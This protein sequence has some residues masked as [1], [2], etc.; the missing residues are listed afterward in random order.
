M[1]LDRVCSLLLSF[2]SFALLS[3]AL[4]APDS[5]AFTNTSWVLDGAGA[6]STNVG[7]AN[8]SSVAQ[9][10]GVEVSTG[11]GFANYAGFLNTFSLRPALDSDG[12]GLVDEV[13]GD[14]DGDGLDDGGENSGS[15]FD[16]R[17]ATNP[18]S[19]DSDGDGADDG[20]EARAGTNPL[21][22]GMYLRIVSVR[23]SGDSVEVGWLARKDWVY[24]VQGGTN[25][26]SA[27]LCPDTVGADL[28]ASG[29][30][31]APWYAMTNFFLDTNAVN[32]RLYRVR[33]SR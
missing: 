4:H 24:D 10:G 15:G 23:S 7:L 21:D 8:V 33:V 29:A 19:P 6:L 13:D 28:V 26:M 30:A 25:I 27:P 9:P 14:N 1:R 16:P 20:S 17:T 31:S 2:L 5:L 3:C 18:N 12:D 22:D 32:Q 11:A